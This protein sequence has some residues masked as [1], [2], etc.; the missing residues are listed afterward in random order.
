MHDCTICI[1]V[2]SFS[3]YFI[4]SIIFHSNNLSSKANTSTLYKEKLLKCKINHDISINHVSL[5]NSNLH[6][7]CECSTNPRY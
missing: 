3:I 6:K 5:L 4:S 2:H 7:V 1:N